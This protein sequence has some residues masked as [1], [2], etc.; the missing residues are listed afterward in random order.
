MFLVHFV[1]LLGSVAAA[2][3]LV[4]YSETDGLTLFLSLLW[5][6][7]YAAVELLRFSKVGWKHFGKNRLYYFANENFVRVE[8]DS[9][10]ST[11]LLLGYRFV[12]CDI[13]LVKFRAD[14]IQKVSWSTGQASALAS[15]DFNDWRILLSIDSSSILASTE[16]QQGSEGCELLILNTKGTKSDAEE[17]GHAFLD[18]LSQNN[19]HLKASARVP[20]RLGRYFDSS[21]E[22][23]AVR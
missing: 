10:G 22:Y 5:P 20:T 15:R 17:M 12:R 18:F 8:H 16:C 1:L 2:R 3:N 23:I 11:L 19:V 13:I 21:V 9:E 6:T 14:G 4:H 7:V